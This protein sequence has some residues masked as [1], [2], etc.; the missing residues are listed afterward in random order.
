MIVSGFET[1][2]YYWAAALTLNFLTC[3][4][5]FCLQPRFRSGYSLPHIFHCIIN[6]CSY[7]RFHYCNTEIQSS[8][9]D[10]LGHFNT[11]FTAFIATGLSRMENQE[12]MLTTHHIGVDPIFGRTLGP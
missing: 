3:N 1:I 7:V 8:L 11:S 12:R 6:P 4:H 2:T 9:V 10:W 5:S